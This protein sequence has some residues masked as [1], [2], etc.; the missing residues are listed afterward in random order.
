MASLFLLV[1]GGRHRKQSCPISLLL[2][3][4]N[5]ENERV[6]YIGHIVLPDMS[7]RS[8]IWYCYYRISAKFLT[9]SL[10][11]QQMYSA[12]IKELMMA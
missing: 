1:R 5:T 2:F 12:K 3:L 7:L 6:Q 4:K 10:L 11:L 9:F 8:N